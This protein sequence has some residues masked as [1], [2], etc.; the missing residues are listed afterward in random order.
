[1]SL[2]TT[3][4]VLKGDQPHAPGSLAAVLAEPSDCTKI[5]VTDRD[6]IVHGHSKN[7]AACVAVSAA[8]QTFAYVAGMLSLLDQPPDFDP[9]VPRYRVHL[10][11]SLS[12]RKAIVGLVSAFAGIGKNATG[13]LLFADN[14]RTFDAAQAIIDEGAMPPEDDRVNGGFAEAVEQRVESDQRIVIPSLYR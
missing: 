12:A 10:E 7:K 9:A 1:V 5:I 6:V 3:G 2:T 8:I 13:S 11:D 4:P 14:R